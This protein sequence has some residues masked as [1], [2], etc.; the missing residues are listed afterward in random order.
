MRARRGA[1]RG[2]RGRARRDRRL[3]PSRG[4]NSRRPTAGVAGRQQP[5]LGQRDQQ[6][7]RR[8][9]PGAPHHPGRAGPARPAGRAGGGGR[10]EH[11][12]LAAVPRVPQQFGV[13]R[14]VRPHPGGGAAGQRLAARTG[15]DRHRRRGQPALRRGHRQRRRPGEGLPGHPLPLQQP[16]RRRP[17][18]RSGPRDQ[19]APASATG[20]DRGPRPG[21]L[22]PR[23]AAAPAAAADRAA[24]AGRWLRA[25]LGRAEPSRGAAEVSRRAAV[26]RAVRLQRRPDP[27]HPP[28]V[29]AEHRCGPA[30][31]H[32]RRLPPRLDRHRHQPGRGHLR[33]D[34]VD[35]GPVPGS[36]A[37]Q[38]HR[39]SGLPDRSGQLVPRAGHGR[40]GRAHHGPAGVDHLLRGEEL[41]APRRHAEQGRRRQQ[42]RGHQQLV[43]C[44]G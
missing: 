22:N 17:T 36:Q 40:A 29:R 8:R 27:Q 19:A 1:G 24:A 39:P 30:G 26:Q 5:E 14:A 44:V 23:G 15:R 13:H 37:V 16:R 42:G 43:G 33:C 9:W 35:A 38:V 34:A 32:R 10:C 41:H 4:Y 6:G 21:R 18:G 2:P 7:R 11:A 31:R 3:F 12:G 25:L 20:R 28:A